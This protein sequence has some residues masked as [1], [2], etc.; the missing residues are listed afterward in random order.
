[1]TASSRPAMD[2]TFYHAEGPSA[3]ALYPSFW[4]LFL[5]PTGNHV[6]ADGT[7]AF[8]IQVCC[9]LGNAYDT[10]GRERDPCVHNSELR[11]AGRN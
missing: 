1:M 7:Y 10:L 5:W 3:T 2:I 8:Q 6:L 11:L 4:L 9:K